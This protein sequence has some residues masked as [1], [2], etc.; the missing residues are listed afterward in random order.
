M[1]TIKIIKNRSDIGA[2]TRGSDMGIDA[3]EIAA[4]NQNNDFFNRYDFED[5]ITENESV[6]D[7]KNNSFGKQINSVLN[8]CKR[9]SNH[10]K[11]NLQEG[12]FPIVL[13][14]DHSS[15][16]G[17]I[18]GV[19]A[20]NPTKRVGVIW[21]DAHGDLHTPYT[22]PS[23]NIHGMPLGAVISDDNLDC[24]INE[25]DRETTDLWDRMKNIGIPGQKAL[26]EDIVFFGVRDTEEP[27]EKQMEKYGIKNYMVAEVR[28]RGLEVCVN[29]ALEKLADCDI[30]YVSFDVDAMDCDMISYGTGTPVAKGFDD[31]EI[32]QII[33][34]LLASKKVACVE[35]V[36]VNPLLDLKGNKMAE[37]AFDVLQQVAKTIEKL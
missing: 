21:I 27:E 24:Q 4:I 9:V 13:S 12:N 37:T 16:L 11:V 5:V 15:A 1:N 36:E 26:P 18:S 20:A 17:T 31:K 8:Q 10:V 3:I 29:E 14:G 2:G 7:K 35:F 30:L 32:V 19:K 23:G 28:Y 25:V 34:G 22:S 33:N 6:Y